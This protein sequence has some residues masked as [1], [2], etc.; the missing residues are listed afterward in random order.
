[1][2]RNSV[3]TQHVRDLVRGHVS[4][5]E[6]TAAWEKLRAALASEMRSRALFA[7]SPTCLGIYGFPSWTEEAVDELVTDCYTRLALSN[8][9]NPC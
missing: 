9:R 3:F 2:I 5:E 4:H 6:L 1:M 8:S 7:A